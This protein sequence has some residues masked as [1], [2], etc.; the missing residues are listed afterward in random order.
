[1]AK[2]D[3]VV[4]IALD[5][6][7]V[8]EQPLGSNTGTR[9]K[10]YQATT[11]LGG[12]GWPWCAAFV[13]W[14]W[15]RAGVPTDIC[16]PYTGTFAARAKAS[17]QVG[18]PRPGAAI[19]WP[20][21]HVE[22]LVSP[23]TSPGVWH[24]VGGNVSDGVRRTVRSIA[25]AVIAVPKALADTPTGA[26]QQYWLEDVGARKLR[27]LYGPWRDTKGL[28]Y[29][30]VIA[31]RARAQGLEATV[32]RVGP[33]QRFATIVG[34]RVIYGPWNDKGHR[35]NARDILQ[36]RLGR[37]LRPYSTPVRLAAGTA[38]ALGKTT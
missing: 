24:C 10:Q 12:T 27:R 16:D 1:M 13:E 34:P 2:G 8:L 15:E 37:L 20:G 21:T 17:G 28:E 19:I 26:P 3:E 7:G 33:G 6:V 35:D 9:V 32:K 23:A 4:R 25:D 5:E 14:C 31:A 30:R 18:A 22:L 38:T 36:G 11:S 29:A